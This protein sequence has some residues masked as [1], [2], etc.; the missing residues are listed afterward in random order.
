MINTVGTSIRKSFRKVFHLSWQE[1]GKFSQNQQGTATTHAGK[2]QK[3]DTNLVYLIEDQE[4]GA[5]ITINFQRN[6]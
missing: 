2:D 1:D 5:Y 4:A 6:A 3:V